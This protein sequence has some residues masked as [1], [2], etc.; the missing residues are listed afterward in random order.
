MQIH[1]RIKRVIRPFLFWRMPAIRRLGFPLRGNNLTALAN[2]YGSDKGDRIHGCHRYTR[3]YEKLFEDVRHKPIQLLEIGLLHPSDA[4]K[5]DAPSLRMWRRYFPHA[6]LFGIDIDDFSRVR[7]R[8]CTIMRGDMANRQFLT[9]F[10]RAN[11]PFD[12][13]IEDASHASHHQQIALGVLFPF[14][15]PGGLY[16]IED[17]NWQPPE[18][19]GA[20]KTRELLRRSMEDNSNS[21]DTPFMTDVE[22][23]YLRSNVAKITLYDSATSAPDK[24][25]ALGI[26]RKALTP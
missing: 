24:K 11:G 25:D 7:I 20:I 13:V 21:W 15:S 14:V 9:A 26:I 16:I 2:Y 19:S 4:G 17:M 18:P 3:I 12:L 6:R 23:T 1:P 22:R 8:N 5:F 10:G